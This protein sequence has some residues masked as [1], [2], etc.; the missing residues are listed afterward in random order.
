MYGGLLVAEVA[1]WFLQR[2]QGHPTACNCETC[3]VIDIS[4]PT[5]L[6]GFF[7]DDSGEDK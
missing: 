4:I 3:V 7:M 5:T 6:L 1:G 2:L